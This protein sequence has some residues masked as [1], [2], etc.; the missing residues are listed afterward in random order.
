VCSFESL[1]NEVVQELELSD[2]ADGSEMKGAD[3][4]IYTIHGTSGV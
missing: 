1:V 2:A 3:T 4:V